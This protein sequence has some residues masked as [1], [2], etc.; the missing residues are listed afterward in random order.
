MGPVTMN[1]KQLEEGLSKLQ[2]LSW[3]DYHQSLETILSESDEKLAF[4]RLGRLIGVSLKQP[5]ATPVPLRSSG[6][7]STGSYRG[8]EL[9]LGSFQ[10]ADVK[11][12]WQYRTLEAIRLEAPD[13]RSFQ[14]VEQ[15]AQDAHYERGFFSY[16]ARSASKYICGD[17]EIL[18]EIDKSV[19]AAKKAGFSTTH[20]RP[21]VLVQAGGLSLGAYLIAHVP[22]FA[23]VGAPVVAG[24]LVVLY[25]IGSDAFCK[26]VN[27][28]FESDDRK[29]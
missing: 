3:G 23:Y 5:F 7:S 6:D 26:Y 4:E 27:D 14:S 21:E 22:V 15:F 13:G 2:E 25:S 20:L 10:H 1:E 19:K 16:L 28:R 24:F 9:E 11:Q 17:P 29:S 8:W 18:K 12:T